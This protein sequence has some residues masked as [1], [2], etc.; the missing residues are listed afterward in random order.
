MEKMGPTWGMVQSN[1]RTDNRWDVGMRGG[2]KQRT[3]VQNPAG[4]K[5]DTVLKRE[6]KSKKSDCFLELKREVGAG[7]QYAFSPKAM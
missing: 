1:Q 5:H 7:I 4:S 2:R 6:G 3:Q